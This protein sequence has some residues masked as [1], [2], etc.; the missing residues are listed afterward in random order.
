MECETT[1]RR[2]PSTTSIH[3]YATASNINIC[4]VSVKHISADPTHQG[5]MK[6]QD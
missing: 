4:N 1:S 2:N 3:H 6:K 5:A